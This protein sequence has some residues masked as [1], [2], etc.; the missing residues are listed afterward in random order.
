[1]KSLSRYWLEFSGTYLSIFLPLTYTL[2]LE[3]SGGI[4]EKLSFSTYFGMEGV[5]ILVIGHKIDYHDNVHTSTCTHMSGMFITAH[6]YLVLPDL[7]YY[8]SPQLMRG[9]TN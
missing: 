4:T 9:N 8:L 1:M 3:S 6:V 5:N 2:N 7:C